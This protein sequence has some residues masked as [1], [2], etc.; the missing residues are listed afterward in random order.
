MLTGI[1]HL[2]RQLFKSLGF[3]V[4]ALGTIALCLGANLAIDADDDAIL[5]RAL[6][7]PDSDR[8]VSRLQQLPG[9]GRREGFSASFANYF[10]RRY[11]IRA[12]SS[13]AVSNDRDVTVGEGGAPIRVATAQVSPEFFSVL[14]V[15]LAMGRSFNDTE[16]TYQTDGVAVLTDG[17][18]RSHFAADPHV[19]GRTFLNDGLS[20]QVIGV[21]PR[22]FRYL[23]KLEFQFTTKRCPMTS[24][25]RQPKS[26]HDNNYNM[27]ARLAP[28]RDLWPTPRRRSTPSTP[29]RP[30][31]IPSRR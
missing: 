28:R 17:F 15:P 31:T 10:D 4:A 22:N 12:F 24:S 20:V 23:L 19:V 30:R 3:A 27:I 14:G 13:L 6:P 25:E 5:V 29:S 1:R 2:V 11:A 8:L 16:L 7:F 26:R 9:R 18:W 21:L